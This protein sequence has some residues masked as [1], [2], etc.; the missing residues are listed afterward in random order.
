MQGKGC[1][2]SYTT[3]VL[4]QLEILDPSLPK[5]ELRHNLVIF[6][7]KNSVTFRETHKFNDDL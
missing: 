5:D 6:K 2:G 3:L 7:I 4:I 1:E